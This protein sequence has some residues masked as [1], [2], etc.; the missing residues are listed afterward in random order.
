MIR[1]ATIRDV[2]AMLA[3]YGPY[4]LETAITF[5]YE[6]PTLEAFTQRFTSI[7]RQFPWL[8]WEEDGE[9]LGYCYGDRAFARAAYQWDAD[10][11]IYLRMDCKGRGIGRKLYHAVEELLRK[12]GYLVAY[13]IVTSSNEASRAFHK[14]MGYEAVAEMKNCGWKFGKWHGITW[15]EKRLQTGDPKGPPVPYKELEVLV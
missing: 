4:I 11:S 15:F 14:A 6:V 12:Q 7:C 9:I 2:P 5:E 13:G 3:I 1:H 10:L 8:V